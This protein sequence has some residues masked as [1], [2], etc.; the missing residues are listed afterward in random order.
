MTSSDHVLIHVV[1]DDAVRLPIE[2]VKNRF[3]PRNLCQ[4]E[5]FAR[6]RLIITPPR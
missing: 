2:T 5:N 4:I 6:K 1:N 3:F